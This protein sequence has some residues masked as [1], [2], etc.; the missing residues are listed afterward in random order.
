[1]SRYVLPPPPGLGPRAG[2]PE[3]KTSASA[4]RAGRVQ[5]V[6]G[7][8]C[9]SRTSSRWFHAGAFRARQLDTAVDKC[10]RALPGPPH[11]LTHS[12]CDRASG[13]GEGWASPHSLERDT[14]GARTLRGKSGGP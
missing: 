6:A 3:T 5:A 8:G 9:R 1:M 10:T 2:P 7:D 11:S 13:R 14:L 12:P 4:R